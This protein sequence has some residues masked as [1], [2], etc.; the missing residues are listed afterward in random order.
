MPWYLYSISAALLYTVMVLFIRYLGN[1]GFSSKQILVFLLGFA[2][3][4]YLIFNIPTINAF[5]RSEYIWTF[6]LTMTIMGV[7]AVLGN[8][9]DFAAIVK[10]PNPGFAEAVKNTN[11]LITLFLSILLFKSSFSVEKFFGVIFMLIGI[12]VLVVDKNNKNIRFQNKENSLLNNWKILASIG[13]ICSSIGILAIKRASQLGFLP[14]QINLFSFGFTFLAT[15]LINL[16]EVK[17]SF[18]DKTK[19]KPFLLI[20]FIAATFSFLA[21]ILNTK[22]ISIAPNIG[23][24]ELLRNSRI[25][26]TTLLS[27]PLLGAKLNKQ[28]L[29]GVF[30]VLIG[31][32]IIVI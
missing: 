25:L 16:K 6:V 21:N 5:L 19:L 31:M 22:G 13:A 32:A 2:F 4:E 24:H 1:K 15:A 18:E 20:V 29:L 23:Y 17:R 12:T 14:I 8:L 27:V 28:K 30:A 7:F 9:A 11:V 3:F 26:F 10:A